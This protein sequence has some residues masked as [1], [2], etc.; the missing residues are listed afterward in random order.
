MR[1][2]HNNLE[3]MYFIAS[4]PPQ[5]NCCLLFHNLQNAW[6]RNYDF[7]LCLCSSYH[8]LVAEV[9]RHY[10]YNS[11]DNCIGIEADTQNFIYS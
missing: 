5:S 7:P 2:L 9:L 4:I 1:P 11:S 10:H 6:G 3:Q 8:P